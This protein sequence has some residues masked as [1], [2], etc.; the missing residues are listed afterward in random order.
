MVTKSEAHICDGGEVDHGE[1]SSAEK[2]GL[3]LTLDDVV[4]RVVGGINIATK[5][6]NKMG[7]IIIVVIF[8]GV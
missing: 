3:G 2:K 8:D 5:R 4:G 1:G 6:N 7:K